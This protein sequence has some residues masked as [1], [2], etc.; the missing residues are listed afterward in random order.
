MGCK[1]NEYLV[2]NTNRPD[3]M[4]EEALG[5]LVRDGCVD[6]LFRLVNNTNRPDWIRNAALEAICAFAHLG[7]VSQSASFSKIT[8]GGKSVS[9]TSINVRV[10]SISGTAAEYLYK[11]ANDTNRPDRMRRIAVETLVTIRHSTYCLKIAD[12]SNRPDWMRKLAMKGL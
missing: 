5:N 6:A 9:S 2:N 11:L 8:I 1:E 12:N 7:N 10:A 3:W 4:R